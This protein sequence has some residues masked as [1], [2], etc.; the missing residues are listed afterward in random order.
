MLL[1]FH[2]DY[3]R[4]SSLVFWRSGDYFLRLSTICN[5]IYTSKY[6]CIRDNRNIYSKTIELNFSKRAYTVMKFG[7]KIN[8]T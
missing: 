2:S 3:K 8:S 6:L 4:L 1:L 5:T 7:F